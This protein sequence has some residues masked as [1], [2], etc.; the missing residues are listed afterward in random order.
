MILVYKRLPPAEL[1]K[2]I[3]GAIASVTA[4]FD[5]R[6]RKRV[7]RLGLN[8]YGPMTVKVRRASIATDIRAAAESAGNVV[9]ERRRR[10]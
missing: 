3:K 1:E 6:P 8:F 2:T 9:I 5:A 4:W 7:C 10:R